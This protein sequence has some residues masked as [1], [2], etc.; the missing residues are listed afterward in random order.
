MSRPGVWPA[1]TD[2][3]PH[4]PPMLLVDR[5]V[6]CVP[7]EWIETEFR[8]GAPDPADGPDPA[9]PD[10]VR[11]PEVLVLESFVQTAAALWILTERLAGTPPR[12][13]LVFAGFRDARF[14]AAVAPGDGV[15]H[16]ATL[17]DRVGSNAFAA[18]ETTSIRRDRAVLR[19]GRVALSA[20]P[21]PSPAG[22]G[23]RRS[24]GL[25]GPLKRPHR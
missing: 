17:L 16:R 7:G 21:A 9:G 12:G 15:R 3:L 19:V 2:L 1:L 23:G 22:V 14:E 24:S 13:A 20:R 4:R 8:L 6:D 5:I 25:R 10:D 11:Y 18:G